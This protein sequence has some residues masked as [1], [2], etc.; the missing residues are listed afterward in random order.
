MLPPS[1]LKVLRPL[2]PPP[3][4]VLARLGG[5]AFLASFRRF[6]SSR[7]Y[8]ASFAS[9]T[10]IPLLACVQSPVTVQLVLPESTFCGLP[11]ESQQTR[12]LLCAKCPWGTSLLYRSTAF[13]N[14]ARTALFSSF[15]GGLNAPLA[16]IKWHFLPSALRPAINSGS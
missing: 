14:S 1:I 12:N 2:A 15:V 5:Y 8:C 10:T 16:R 9:L 13:F 6:H 11:D 3:P 7:K 4:L